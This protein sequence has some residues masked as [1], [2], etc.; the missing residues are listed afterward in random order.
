MYNYTGDKYIN[1]MVVEPLDK[2]NN[3]E[4]TWTN[5]NNWNKMEILLC[6]SSD[7]EGLDMILIH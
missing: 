5:L 7:A 6:T 3:I 2:E 1:N 4:I